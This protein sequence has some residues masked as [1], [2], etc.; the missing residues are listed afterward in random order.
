[1]IS[2]AG[3]ATAPTRGTLFEYLKQT[4]RLLH[5]GKM[6][7]LDP[8]DLIEYVNRSRRE[9]A[10]RTQCL[11][12]LTPITG[13]IKSIDVTAGGSGYT[14]PS[15]LITPPDFPSG[16]QPNPNGKQATAICSLGG[17]SITSVNLTYGGAGYFQPNVSIVDPTGNGAIL[18]P[19]LSFMNLQQEGQEVYPFAGV[20]TSMWP[21][22]DAIFAVLSVSIIYANYRYS[23][24]Q[25]S[26]STYQAYIRQ[27]PFQY[28][29]VPTICAQYGQGT[30][31][32]IY[33]YPIA[34]QPYQ[35]EWDCLCLP[36][37][38]I[39][40]QDYEAL[41]RPWTDGVP[42]MAAYFA[43]MDLQ[44]FNSARFMSSEFDRFMTR[45]GAYARPGRWS[46]PYGRF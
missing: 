40:D 14:A 26:F 22:V 46:N 45:Y 8:A 34:S 19:N 25:Y 1:M 2:Y 6:E 7:M 20:D 18:S 12:R 37:D 27:Y 28:Q 16:A 13:S 9:V 30:D 33:F 3:P 41:P 4:Q 11:R 44:N 35:M 15:V 43:F 17:G 5:D 31:G 39:R 29:Y 21:G 36:S 42:Y 23:L 32:S 10:M 38:L 24:P